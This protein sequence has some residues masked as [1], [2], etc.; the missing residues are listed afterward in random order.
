MNFGFPIHTEIIYLL[1]KLKAEDV[2][3]MKDGKKQNVYLERFVGQ[4]EIG[5]KNGL[6][7]YQIYLEHLIVLRQVKI[8][9]AMKK[10]RCHIMV[11]KVYTDKYALYCIKETDKFQFES[12]YC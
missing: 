2:N 7:H 8:I 10:N 4:V 9:N 3:K 11:N 6:P 12:P 5:S 1:K